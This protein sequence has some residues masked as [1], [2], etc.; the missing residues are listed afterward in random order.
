ME[1][2]SKFVPENIPKYHSIEWLAQET[3]WHKKR[4]D[5]DIVMEMF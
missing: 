3:G 2:D 4:F 5:P 1:K